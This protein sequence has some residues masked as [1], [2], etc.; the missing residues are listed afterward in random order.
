MGEIR[1]Y[2]SSNLSPE[3][4][5]V[6]QNPIPDKDGNL[7]AEHHRLTSE[8]EFPA[9][10]NIIN[11]DSPIFRNWENATTGTDYM[12][13]YMKQNL[14]L[15]ED[16]ES[17]IF[18][19]L[20]K[21]YFDKNLPKEYCQK[22][23]DKWRNI[24]E[25]AFTEY[26]SNP[27]QIL[28]KV[29]DQ[30]DYDT[31]YNHIELFNRSE[32]RNN[33]EK[34]FELGLSSAV[35]PRIIIHCGRIENILKHDNNQSY[36]DPEF[37]LI[38]T[39]LSEQLVENE[40]IYTVIDQI[41]NGFISIKDVT[42]PNNNLKTVLDMVTLLY[43]SILT[44]DQTV[45]LI[46][47]MSFQTFKVAINDENSK[48]TSIG[49][50]LETLHSDCSIND[51]KSILSLSGLWKPSSSS[52]YRYLKD[53]DQVIQTLNLNKT[54]DIRRFFEKSQVLRRFNKE[55]YQ[56]YYSKRAP[57]LISHLPDF[58]D[59][60][61]LYHLNLRNIF[62]N[63]IHDISLPNVQTDNH[64]LKTYLCEQFC[65]IFFNENNILSGDIDSE[66][67]LVY[68]IWEFMMEIDNTSYEAYKSS[69][70]FHHV[71]QYDLTNRIPE[72]ERHDLQTFE[73][74]DI[75][76][77]LALH[78]MSYHIFK[79]FFLK[80]RDKI[81]LADLEFKQVLIKIYGLDPLGQEE[82]S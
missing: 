41:S 31:G 79:Q 7:Q 20:D 59:K 4:Q 18:V 52:I 29:L 65:E 30:E 15:T 48:N 76:F 33:Q 40:K 50:E 69:C 5:L 22:L 63:L 28:I 39:Q 8:L 46:T 60:L 35:I 77:H 47:E 58:Q 43:C 21:S 78:F 56:K 23:M 74:M 44:S 49:A 68:K 73:D 53:F 13:R 6:M 75:Q 27:P 70:M 26:Q 12:S 72:L 38:H 71:S 10:R 80:L 17:A 34:S 57:R 67:R 11:S 45:N 61:D 66:L 55:L 81:S 51:I 54:S 9:K 64:G 2:E 3:L 62:D 24:H 82:L 36:E 32:N 19:L 25:I 1:Q 42:N 37:C 16:P 14:N